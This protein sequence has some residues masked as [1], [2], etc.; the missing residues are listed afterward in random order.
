MEWRVENAK[1]VGHVDAW[2]YEPESIVD[3]YGRK[4]MLDNV[5]ICPGHG[6]GVAAIAGGRDLGAASGAQLYLMKF[7]VNLVNP[8][9]HDPNNKYCK[10]LALQSWRSI[11]EALRFILETVQD[12]PKQKKAVILSTS[13]NP[14]TFYRCFV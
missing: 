6:T 14:S 1:A 13:G 10:Y 12:N 4:E 5:E 2:K 8:D 9:Y 11:D 3:W 7:A